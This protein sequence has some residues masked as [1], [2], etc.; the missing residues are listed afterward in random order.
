M[1]KHV[2]STLSADTRYVGWDKSN[3]VN[4]VSRSV[5]VRGG[6]GVALLG[7]GQRVLT[8]YGVRTEVTDD[9]AKFLSEHPQFLEHQKRNHV[10]IENVARDPEKVAQKMDKDERGAQKTPEDVQKDA[11]EAA[12]KSGLKPEETL[13]V[14]TNKGK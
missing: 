12:K 7:A 9:D 2:F 3:G 1:A 10:R 8:P 13:G 5:L 14:A 4:T 11:E 6:S